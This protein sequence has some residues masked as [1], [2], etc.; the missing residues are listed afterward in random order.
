MYNRLITRWK[1]MPEK[2]FEEFLLDLKKYLRKNLV[3]EKLPSGEPCWVCEFSHADQMNGGLDPRIDRFKYSRRFCY[4]N[5]L[6]WDEVKE[7]IEDHK[8]ETIL[9]DCE[10]LM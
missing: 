6:D 10:I 9:C 2:K 8:G 5:K 7:M 4:E 1:L 3:A